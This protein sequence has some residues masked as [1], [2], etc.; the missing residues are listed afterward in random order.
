MPMPAAR[1]RR[2][3]VV[4]PFLDEAEN[5]PPLYER[6]RIAL[7][8]EPES[9]EVLFV[10]DGS[11]D[12]GAAW[13]AARAAEDPRIRLL[14]LSRNFG[15]QLAI[16]AG[17]DHAEG[18]AVVIMDADLQDPPEVVPELLKSWRAGHEIVY[19]V[20]T[21][22][23]GESW[24]KRFLAATFYKTFRRMANVDV[25]LDAGDFRLVDRKV[26]DALKQVR[27]LH[28]FVR[29]LTCWVGF[30]QA[31]VPYE[32]AA[33]HAGATKYPVWKS[34]RLAWDAITSFSST[35]LRWMTTIG[36]LVSLAGLLQ[37]VR[38]VVDRLL[39]PGSMERGWA[40]LAAITLFLG[41]VQ[42]ISL[43]LIGQYVGRI[44]EESKKRP[45]YFVRDKVGFEEP[46]AKS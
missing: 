10:D 27:E 41:G 35:P 31:A 29:G 45:L 8:D 7:A 16:T 36:L 13:V 20:R 18:D 14:R 17:M 25:P 9:F 3:T 30:S 37:A 32:R 43:G 5:L 15:H 44:F 28:R 39:Y 11:K 12:G 2:V 33:R 34:M 46:R 6:L 19:A 22:R 26:I 24:T 38:V 40:S 4:V 1:R 21:S 23:S 42:L